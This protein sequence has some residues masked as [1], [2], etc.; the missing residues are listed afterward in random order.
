LFLVLAVILLRA[1]VR[2]GVLATADLVVLSL[3]LLLS[4]YVLAAALT[5]LWRGIGFF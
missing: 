4:L 2:G 3:D 5:S 1:S